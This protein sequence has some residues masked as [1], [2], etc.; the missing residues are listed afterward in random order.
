ML[1]RCLSWRGGSSL[2]LDGSDSSLSRFKWF[3]A[4][5]NTRKRLSKRVKAL[6]RLARGQSGSRV[7]FRIFTKNRKVRSRCVYLKRFDTQFLWRESVY[8]FVHVVFKERFNGRAT[9]VT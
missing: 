4:A 7:M 9:S 2:E 3:K 6:C 5:R 8:R 1:D